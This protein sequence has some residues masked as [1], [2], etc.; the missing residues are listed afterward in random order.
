MKCNRRMK[1]I[2]MLIGV[3]VLMLCMSACGKEQKAETKDETQAITEAEVNTNKKSGELI[4]ETKEYTGEKY[5]YEIIENRNAEWQ[6]IVSWQVNVYEGDLF[7]QEIYYEHDEDAGA[8]ADHE[9][10]IWEADVNFDGFKDLL[11]C[12]GHYGAQ[13]ALGYR[14]Y[15]A[16]TIA[17]GF[18]YCEGFEDISNP[19]IDPVNKCIRSMIR[20]NAVSYYEE[21]YA[22]N[23]AD[24]VLI[25][26]DT[27][28]WD[29][30]SNQ[31][32]LV[33]S[34]DS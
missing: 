32:K 25:K 33:H 27:Y 18:D 1:C 34:T 10:I 22:Y 30:E 8:L 3:M 17:A 2:C 6:E 15:L 7:I 14:C 12:Q 29:D 16:N 31:Y 5:H 4:S 24:F 11:I 9:N 23:G 13:G 26:K 28:E 20:S 21:F 19:Q